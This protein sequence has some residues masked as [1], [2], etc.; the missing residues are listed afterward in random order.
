MALFAFALCL[1]LL[2]AA[3]L[4]DFELKRWAKWR[5]IVLGGSPSSEFVRVE[6][7]GK[8][9]DAA[10]PDLDDLR[11]VDEQRNEVASKVVV[12]KP[13]LFP[14]QKKPARLST[15]L[16]DQSKQKPEFGE[17]ERNQLARFKGVLEKEASKIL[18]DLGAR[19]TPSVRI[20]LEPESTNFRRRIVVL[21]SN[22]DKDWQTVGDT[23]IF[24]IRVGKVRRQQLSIDYDEVRYRYLSVTIFNYDDQ[25]LKMRE[26]RVYGWPRQLLFRREPGRSYRLFYGNPKA[27]A[28]R[29]DL[30]QLSSYLKPEELPLAT[31]GSERAN[32]SFT[33]ETDASKPDRHP[34]WLWATLAVAAVVLGALIYRLA[35]M[36]T[37][38]QAEG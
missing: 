25:P 13:D 21:G 28:P 30:E 31:L 3:V 29:Y 10:Q 22:D 17:G 36:T 24:D 16:I 7:D 37:S 9:F 4:A 1:S 12:V 35:K 19:N 23:E 18:I 5:E 27:A 26:V 32:E 2:P 20:E 14:N 33:A 38:G 34:A 15:T 8:V 11:V 6:L